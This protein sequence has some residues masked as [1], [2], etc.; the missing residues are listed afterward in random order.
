[1]IRATRSWAPPHMRHWNDAMAREA[2]EIGRTGPALSF[3]FGCMVWAAGAG[4]T[5]AVRN[6]LWPDGTTDGDSTMTAH[7]SWRGRGLTLVCAIAAT[8][9]GLIYLNSAGAPA[10]MLTMNLAALAAG[11]IIVLPLMR[12]EPVD[13]P[14]AG[15]LAVL[16]GAALLLTATMGQ[17]AAGVRRWIS[18][19]GVV[20]QPSLI[21]LPIMIV[22]FARTRDLLTT[23]GVVIAAIALTVQPDRAMAGAL[24]A[25]LAVIA[26]YTRDR[27]GAHCLIAASVAFAI[28]WLRPDAAPATPFVDRVF[29]TAFATGFISGAAVW[30]GVILLILPAALGVLF[31]RRYRPIHAAFG[32]TW[33]A[34]IVA[35]IVADYPTP[36]VAYSGSSIVGY[37]LAA[38]ALPQRWSASS[39]PVNDMDG[40][41]KAP[42]TPDADLL[43]PEYAAR[44]AG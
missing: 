23:S 6:A 17:D 15:I 13:R 10:R 33:T 32:A 4:L 24:V 29:R 22:A 5:D 14:F 21:L 42:R 16:V 36:L 40:R 35:A 7:P 37:I 8:A 9:L 25:G 19:G 43:I 39:K 28:T 38:V 11:L 3:A 18:V 1:M 31:D 34:I 26:M 20:V 44:R 41:A 30:A 12:R 2:A 27:A